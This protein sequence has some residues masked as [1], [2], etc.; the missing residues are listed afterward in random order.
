MPQYRIL[1]YN[2]KKNRCKFTP[3]F[4][5]V[6]LACLT[7]CVFIQKLIQNTPYKL[8]WHYSRLTKA[9]IA[10]EYILIFIPQ[11]YKNK[12]IITVIIPATP[13]AIL[14]IAP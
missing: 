12:E 1:L 14:L 2:N 8:S 4:L 9:H 3:V 6:I 5:I 10:I 13:N 7:F 11:A